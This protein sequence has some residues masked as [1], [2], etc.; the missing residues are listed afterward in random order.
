MTNKAIA[1]V[2]SAHV[3]DFTV[4]FA[5]Y[6]KKLTGDK[7][8]LYVQ[9]A[10]SFRAHK[11]Y[12]E[13]GSVDKLVDFHL[14]HHYA[15]K[16]SGS[17]HIYSRARKMEREMGF[18]INYL[19]MARREAG[20]GFALGGFGHPRVPFTDMVNHAQLVHAACDMVDFWRTEIIQHNLGLILNGNK[21]CAVACQLAG[22]PF[23]TM[24]ATRYKNLYYWAHDEFVGP[25]NLAEAYSA[26]GERSRDPIVLNAPYF[27]E[28]STRKL[29]VG[30]N[31][32]LRFIKFFKKIVLRYL[33][34]RAKG[35]LSVTHAYFWES[36]R[37]HW[38]YW[39]DGALLKA[40]RTRPLSSLDGT[41]FV[42]FPL[43]TEPE[44]SL[45]VMS[46]E[47]I[48]QLGAIA[49]LARDLPAGAVLA[50][51]ETVWGLGRRPRDF[52][53]QIQEFTNVVLL[54]VKE[55]G[56]DVVKKAAAVATISGSAGIEAALQGRPVVLFGRHNG[57]EF[58][59]HVTL[60][61][62]EEE[63]APALARIFDGEIDP[64]CSIAAGARYGEALE[65]ISFDFEG[66]A[67]FRPDGWTPRNIEA[68]A[69]ALFDSLRELNDSAKVRI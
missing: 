50:V 36:A 53:R 24:Y 49:S 12:V 52:Y 65:R 7:I 26:V 8:I 1:I 20:R 60:I 57:Y 66:F 13:S 33:Y 56:L 30:D 9:G 67:A 19:L 34:L 62:R 47:F 18:P 4:A 32:C 68:A 14:F 2:T 42:F 10:E 48:C 40:P 37:Y 11:K 38:R 69:T 22:I 31:G 27:H 17:A 23:R 3:K 59:P 15:Q 63:L 45:Q 46:P 64:V 54:D 5:E 55:R 35:Y 39:R 21:E 43:Q 25:P 51:K 41:P 44:F 61:N 29:F 58:L 6:L 28:T 16:A